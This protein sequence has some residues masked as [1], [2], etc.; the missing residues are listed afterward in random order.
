MFG[1]GGTGT[2]VADTFRT[3]FGAHCPVG[4]CDVYLWVDIGCTCVLCI[5]GC[6]CVLC[7]SGCTRVLCISGCTCVLCISGC[8]C[9]QRCVSRTAQTGAR[10]TPQAVKEGGRSCGSHTTRGRGQQATDLQNRTREGAVVRLQIRARR[11]DVQGMETL[12]T[13][14]SDFLFFFSIYLYLS[15]L[16]FVLSNF[17][18]TR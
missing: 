8:T 5:S 10:P 12:P 2:A 11:L 1:A 16:P 4:V 13:V 18:G 14:R 3:D 9:V 7:I 15:S 6:T 17:V